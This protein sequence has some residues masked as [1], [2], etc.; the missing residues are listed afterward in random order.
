M[1]NLG[2]SFSLCVSIEIFVLGDL[3]WILQPLCL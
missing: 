1:D 3:R 2:E